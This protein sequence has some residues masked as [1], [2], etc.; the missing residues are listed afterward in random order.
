MCPMGEAAD[1]R[2]WARGLISEEPSPSCGA[3]GRTGELGRLCTALT[4]VVPAT[5]AG[6]TAA[7]TAA[8][9]ML[10]AASSKQA[11]HLEEIQTTLG[12]GPCVDAARYHRPV[13]ESNLAARG[14]QRW[15]AYAPAA[16]DLGV[17]AVF[18]FPLQV[19][20]ACL[21]VLDVYQQAPGFLSD[22]GLADALIFTEVAVEILLDDQQDVVGQTHLPLGAGLTPLALYQAQG[23]VTVQLGVS[24]TEAMARIRARA[25]ANDRHLSLV[26]QD[27]VN[28][29]MFLTRDGRQ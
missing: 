28:G 18:A 3:M 12:Q 1:Q 5:G 20:A 26:A 22:A 6:M 14:Q 19:G 9:P 25:Y 7:V 13:L 15:P 21:G 27:I 4:R 16:R 10:L 2:S 17:G 8:P 24:L 11:E 29:S 23:M